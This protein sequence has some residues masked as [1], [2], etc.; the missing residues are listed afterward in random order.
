M[1]KTG[2]CRWFC[3]MTR[4]SFLAQ[5]LGS[6]GRILGAWRS[7]WDKRVTVFGWSQVSG[8]MWDILCLHQKS[9][10][11]IWWTSVYEFI[12]F[13]LLITPA[14]QFCLSVKM[15]TLIISFTLPQRFVGF[16]LWVKGLFDKF[17]LWLSLVLFCVGSGDCGLENVDKPMPVPSQPDLI[18]RYAANWLSIC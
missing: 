18:Y 11:F 5:S 16:N 12:S 13:V 15:Q 14:L 17:V 2:K 7:L 3:T 10:I 8:K 9:N 6:S 4:F 1:P